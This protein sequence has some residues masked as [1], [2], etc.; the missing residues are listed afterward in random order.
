MYSHGTAPRGYVTEYMHKSTVIKRKEKKS[1]LATCDA[2]SRRRDAKPEHLKKK[3]IVST[4]EGPYLVGLLSRPQLVRR[5]YHGQPAVAD[6][7]GEP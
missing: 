2:V 5:P 4:I 7:P 1:T 3:K 6:D